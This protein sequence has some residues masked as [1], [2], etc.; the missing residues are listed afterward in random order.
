MKAP[1]VFP[2]SCN[3]SSNNPQYSEMLLDWLL[4]QF[5]KDKRFFEKA[6]LEQFHIKQ[7]FDD[8]QIDSD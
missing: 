3:Q 2:S 4:K 6:R 5:E 1:N 7:R 8:V